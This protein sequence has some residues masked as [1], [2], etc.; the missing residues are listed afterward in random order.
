MAPSM[1]SQLVKQQM[2][3]GPLCNSM[4]EPWKIFLKPQGRKS[5]QHLIM[6]CVFEFHNIAVSLPE[7]LI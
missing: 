7:S 3:V 4:G 6:L 2:G 5:E 1:L